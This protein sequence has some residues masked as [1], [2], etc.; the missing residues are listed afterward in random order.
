M[1]TKKKNDNP[2]GTVQDPKPGE[3]VKEP[4]QDPKPDEQIPSP[5]TVYAD[6]AEDME[7]RARQPA[8]TAP[9]TD[10]E[11]EDDPLTIKGRVLLENYPEAEEI[12]M[13][14]DGFGFFE[15]QGAYNHAAT[16]KKP[17][18]VHVKK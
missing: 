16:I 1:A 5:A 11:N 18:I 15:E 17:T 9:A 12:F 2:E 3:Q 6:T 13:T 14:A 7:E 4:E 8:E 10:A